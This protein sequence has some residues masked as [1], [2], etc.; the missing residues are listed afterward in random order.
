MNGAPK[1]G[2]GDHLTRTDQRM[3]YHELSRSNLPA[4]GRWY[5]VAGLLLLVTLW[6][7]AVSST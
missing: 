2:S 3:L 7:W 5:M 4:T 6:E 1:P